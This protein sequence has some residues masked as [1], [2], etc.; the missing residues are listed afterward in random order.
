[1]GEYKVIEKSV[2]RALK[3]LLNVASTDTAREFLQSI[4][5]D[6][7]AGYACTADGF[8]LTFIDYVA[9]GL[10]SLGLES[11]NYIVHMGTL[12]RKTIAEF[13]KLDEKYPNILTVLHPETSK[14]VIT[15]SLN[16]HLLKKL[17]AEADGMVTI[18]VWEKTQPIEM[19]FNINS[20]PVFAALMP[21]HTADAENK[22]WKP[23]NQTETETKND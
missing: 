2:A 1:M 16:S 6:K 7:E 20:H 18:S 9:S 3:H 10:D 13:I 19:N 8:M 11:G 22:A 5:I 14:P 23:K 15:F 4:H 12:Q 17:V 21:M